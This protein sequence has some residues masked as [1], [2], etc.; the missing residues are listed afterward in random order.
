MVVLCGLKK[1]ASLEGQSLLPLLKQVD[2][3]WDKPARTMVYHKQVLGRSIRTARWR[4]SEWDGG[5][6]GVELYDHQNDP[7]E[8]HNL[9]GAPRF[10][11]T[12]ADMKRSL[13]TSP[14]P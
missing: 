2:A 8:Y 10:A 12:V 13:G 14:R 1:P 11:E 5:K 7:G 3:A 9:A 6:K 4:Y